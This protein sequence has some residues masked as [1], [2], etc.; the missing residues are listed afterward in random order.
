MRDASGFLVFCCSIDS[1]AGNVSL[2]LLLQIFC[3]WTIC[4]DFIALQIANYVQG[5]TFGGGNAVLM[6]VRSLTR[7]ASALLWRTDEPRSPDVRSSNCNCVAFCG[8]EGC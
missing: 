6:L 5:C 2:S 8:S 7:A 1:S 3:D 4:I